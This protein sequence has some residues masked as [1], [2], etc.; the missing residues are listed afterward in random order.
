MDKK[1]EKLREYL[2]MD[3]DIVFEEFKEYYSGVIGEL[4]SSFDSF[5][6]EDCFKA[7]YI[8]KILHSNAEARSHKSKKDAKAFRKMA[9]KSSFWVEA[10]DYRL[11]RDGLS[12][13]DIEEAVARLDS[14]ME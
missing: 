13:S 5:E 3:E 11:Q 8:L 4:N 12:K 14:T 9:E 1:L 10:I 7:R 6:N 2:K